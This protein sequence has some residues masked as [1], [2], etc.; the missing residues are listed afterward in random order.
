MNKKIGFLGLGLLG[1]LV[2]GSISFSAFAQD[3][4]FT[5][6]PMEDNI[7]YSE[8]VPEQLI[9]GLKTSDPNFHAKA[10]LNG[11]QDLASI[12][13]IHAHLIKVPINNE[14]K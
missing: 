14:E 7:D 1:I 9:V 4:L 10:A 2:I 8:F 5:I 11:G 13:Q 3:S 12:N 6:I